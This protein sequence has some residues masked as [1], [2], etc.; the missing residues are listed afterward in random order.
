M[1]RRRFALC[2][3]LF[4]LASAK[5]W[6]E[7]DDLLAPDRSIEDVV[8]HYIDAKFADAEVNPAEQA[9]EANLIT[10]CMWGVGNRN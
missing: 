4:A 10:L 5:A 7:A 1:H 6:A 3:A 8:D 2:L 9:D